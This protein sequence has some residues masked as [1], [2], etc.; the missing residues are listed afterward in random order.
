MHPLTYLVSAAIAVEPA[1]MLEGVN[2]SVIN[3]YA[4]QGPCQEQAKRAEW[5]SADASKRIAGC[6][7]AQGQQLQIVFFDGDAMRAPISAVKPVSAL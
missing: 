3:L 5:V 6:W 4:E 7:I 2:G 1:A